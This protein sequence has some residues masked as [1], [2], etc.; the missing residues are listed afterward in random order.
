[1]EKPTPQQIETVGKYALLTVA[2]VLGGVALITALVDVVVHYLA[3][4]SARM[5]QAIIKRREKQKGEE[6]NYSDLSAVAIVKSVW[7]IVY[8][9][10]KYSS[11]ASEVIQDYDDQAYQAHLAAMA[12]SDEVVEEIKIGGTE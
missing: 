12:Q 6:I 10:P 3:S 4:Q 7:T 11:P 9:D 5:M 1:M 8:A 2:G